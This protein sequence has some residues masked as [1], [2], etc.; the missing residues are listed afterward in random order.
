MTKIVR[1]ASMRGYHHI[2]VKFGGGEPT[3]NGAGFLKDAA[4]IIRALE[5]DDMTFRL[6]LLSNGIAVTDELVKIL[7]ENNIHTS[8]ST[9]PYRRL[10][11]NTP[12]FPLVLEN[13]K[14]MKQSGVSVSAQFTV[15]SMNFQQAEEIYETLA[16]HEVHLH[17]AL[18]R[19]QTK[20]QFVF[21][22]TEKI[23][24]GMMRVY[25]RAFE[26]IEKGI[27]VGNI[28]SFD[29]LRLGGVKTGVCG[30]GKTYIVLDT[31]GSV[32]SC[33]E[34]IRTRESGGNL[35]SDETNV[36]DMVDRAHAVPKEQRYTATMDGA[37]KYPFMWQGGGGCPWSAEKQKG[38]YNASVDHVV[39]IYETL[40]RVMLALNVKLQKKLL[41]SRA[42]VTEAWRSPGERDCH[43][44]DLRH[45]MSGSGLAMTEWQ[46]GG[47]EPC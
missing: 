29:Y 13:L 47:G 39:Q 12:A 41:S 27:F 31:D 40:A 36:F 43:A 22:Q 42:E 26:R 3:L 7:R 1:D 45:P 15:S 21:V 44:R 11:K 30:A 34:K 46:E 24:E 9:D 6:V 38:T 32:Y 5:D 20:E 28:S 35:L 23:L 14:K 19:P 17:F 4:R 10:G 33:H 2:Q 8:V 37:R 18:F 16:A 25:A